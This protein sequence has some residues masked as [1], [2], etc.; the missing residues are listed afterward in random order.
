MDEKINFLG[1]LQRLEIKQGDRFVLMVDDVI[2]D[3]TA[4]HIQTLWAQFIGAEGPKLLILQRG[5]KLGVIGAVP[6]PEKDP[7]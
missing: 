5:M 4:T 3:S 7:A 1:D 6:E 2:S